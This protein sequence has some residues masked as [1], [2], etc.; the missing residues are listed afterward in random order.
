MKKI[1]EIVLL[2]IIA[3]SA[4]GQRDF[5]HLKDQPYLKYYE[6]HPFDCD[7]VPDS[8]YSNLTDRICANI[9]LQKSDS[10]CSSYIDSV[11]TEILK[12]ENDTLLIQFDSLQ[13]GWRKFRD[14]HTDLIWMSY[15][16]CGGCHSRATH[17]MTSSRQLTEIRISELKLL[18][19]L[20]RKEGD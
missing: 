2:I 15:E 11:R 12:W 3:K 4:I 10:I 5:N 8:L 14:K 18:L 9:W 19:E 13:S 17:F 6:S 7:S 1:I 16:G 20:Y